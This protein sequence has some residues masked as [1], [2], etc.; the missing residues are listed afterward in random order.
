MTDHGEREAPLE[1]VLHP[2][3]RFDNSN[4]S[5][6]TPIKRFYHDREPDGVHK[7]ANIVT[8]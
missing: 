1:S 8:G 3:C 4:A 2:I 6:S 7:C 5:P